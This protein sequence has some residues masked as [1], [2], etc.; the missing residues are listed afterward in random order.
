MKNQAIKPIKKSVFCE[1]LD[2]LRKSL[3]FDYD[4]AEIATMI[5]GWIKDNEAY[6]EGTVLDKE[7]SILEF[8][9]LVVEDYP[10][11]FC[12]NSD[13]KY[14]FGNFI[15]L[16]EEGFIKFHSYKGGF[17][18]MKL[19]GFLDYL[20]FLEVDGWCDRCRELQGFSVVK[21]EEKIVCECRVC[22]FF[23]DVG[24]GGDLKTGRLNA[25]TVY[26]LKELG[27]IV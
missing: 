24:K 10:V 18:A 26:E 13:I 25:L 3:D 21:L 6:I 14:G 9:D 22:G 17:F 15:K 19:R 20:F 8:R 23:R 2:V 1:F 11:N 12:D 5:I 4:N 7:Y 16:Y 27:F